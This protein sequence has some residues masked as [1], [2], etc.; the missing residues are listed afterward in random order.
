MLQAHSPLW[1]YLW[2]APNL[3]LLVIAFVLWR[4]GFGRTHPSFLAF[5]CVGS[6]GQLSL[7]AADVLSWVTP[8]AFWHVLWSGLL[9]E[10]LVKFVLIG[11]LFLHMFG[12]YPSIA[13]LGKVLIRGTGV[14]LVFVAALAAGFSQTANAYFLVSGSHLLE[15]TVYIIELGLLLFIFVFSAYFR[16][17]AERTD[18]GICIGLA[19]SASVQLAI[20]AFAAGNLSAQVSV[21]LDLLNMAT[22]HLCVLIW[23]YYLFVPGRLTARATV[24][25]PEN[26]L[27]LWNRELE[28]LLQ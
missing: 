2:V 25:L 26:N 13:K 28:R 23:G 16:L 19:I 4:R 1:N 8:K 3:Y 7:Y 11:E 18:R 27:A 6:I 14:V 24:A 21:R 22:Y 17:G 5:C 20:W 15:Q 9:I 10:S 12:P